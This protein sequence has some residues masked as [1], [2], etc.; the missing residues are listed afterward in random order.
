SSLV[1]DLAHWGVADPA[2]LTFLDPPPG[3]ALAEAKALLR[4]LGAINADGR[5]TAEG[6]ALGSLP[7]PP[8]LAR[9]GV[10]AGREGASSS[11][12]AIAVILTERGLGGDDADL[13]YRLDA[14]RRD[15][16]RRAEEARAMAKRWA[17]TI[18]SSAGP[19]PAPVGALLALAYPD[20]L[21]KNRGGGPGAFLLANGRGAQIDP[22]SPLAREP[23][24]AVAEVVGSAAQGRIVL[25]AAISP[26]EIEARFADRIEARN[27]VTCDPQSLSLRGRRTR[28]FGA[29]TLA[30]QPVPVTAG[31]AAGRTRA[32]G[33]CNAGP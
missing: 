21:A 24:L 28:R 22:A 33:I 30:E 20:R 1:L 17:A 15:R 3:P 7:L 31:D 6:K 12:A 8:R 18:E 19:Q 11:A 32:G 23:Y 13:A 5:I 16:S 2:G 4:D 10:D 9:L 27:E 25:A 14:L 26:D 29:I